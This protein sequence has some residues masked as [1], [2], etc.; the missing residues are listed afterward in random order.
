MIRTFTIKELNHWFYKTQPYVYLV[1]LTLQ[2]E[3][4]LRF[5]SFGLKI[6]IKFRK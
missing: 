4:F 5:S 2:K 1:F 6:E 3:K